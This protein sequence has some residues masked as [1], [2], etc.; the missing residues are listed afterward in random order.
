ML[1]GRALTRAGGMCMLRRRRAWRSGVCAGRRS[2]GGRGASGCKGGC[3]VSP[4]SCGVASVVCCPRSLVLGPMK[5]LPLTHSFLL[6]LA[7][8]HTPFPIRCASV[9]LHPTP[10]VPS[11]LS[12]SVNQFYLLSLF[13]PLVSIICKTKCTA[14]YVSSISHDPWTPFSKLQFFFFSILLPRLPHFHSI[15]KSNCVTVTRYM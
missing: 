4:P 14:S 7:H 6:F 8:T 10:P 9:P 12:R 5:L 1:R 15:L 3:R 11:S 2:G 13:L